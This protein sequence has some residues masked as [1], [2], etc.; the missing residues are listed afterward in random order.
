MAVI[1]FRLTTINQSILQYL[2]WMF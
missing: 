1:N 2:A